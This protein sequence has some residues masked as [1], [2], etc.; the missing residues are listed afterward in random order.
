MTPSTE[1]SSRD[2]ESARASATEE[3]E[4]GAG[5]RGSRGG[6]GAAAARV[7][8]F[9]IIGH[10]LCGTTALYTIL[11][12]HPEIFM[13][14]LK[15]PRFFVADRSQ[16]ADSD[17]GARRGIRPHTLEEYLA[18]FADARPGQLTGE[19]SP[20]Y[21][22]SEEAAGLI[23]GARPDARVIAILREP[24]SFLRTFHN[25]CVRGGIEDQND[26]RKALE[27]EPMRREGKRMPRGSPGPKRLLYSE[28]VRYVEQ[29]RRFRAVFPP[30]QV[31]VIIYED[32]RRDNDATVRRIQRFLAVDDAVA[33]ERA[34]SKRTRKA[35]RFQRL[36]RLA[37]SIQR[38]RRRPAAAGRLARAAD[39]L[40]P[41]VLRKR[42]VEE[43][44]R[45]V[46]FSAP[47]PLADEF[48]LELRRRFKSEVEMLSDYLGR[49]LVSFWGYDDLE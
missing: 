22:R 48:M 8:D 17:A 11:R 35:V 41:S 31:L 3:K 2:G 45:R 19:A 43:L 5:E 25:Q 47:P 12:Q 40:T 1:S 28:H 23:A 9:F 18:L 21:I 4:A 38:A 27:L 46:I 16:C 32:F 34:D 7:P 36:H 33:L 44:A 49:D 39:T 29:L 30:E 14:D 13:P 37:A 20:Q 26:F 15:E 24:T 10:E 42:P 6:V